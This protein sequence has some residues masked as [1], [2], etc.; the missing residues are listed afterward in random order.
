MREIVLDTEQHGIDAGQFRGVR[1]MQPDQSDCRVGLVD[2]AIGVDPKIVFRAPFAGAKSG[3]A[4]I[5]GLCVDLVQPDH[6]GGLP[7]MRAR[8]E[9][10][11]RPRLYIDCNHDDDDGHE[12]EDDAPAHQVL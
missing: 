12:L 10:R 5:A 1:G 11:L 7:C 4:V 2:G 6:R 9:R 3:R 8:S